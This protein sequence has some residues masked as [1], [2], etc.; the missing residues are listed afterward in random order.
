MV[1]GIKFLLFLQQQT[2]FL[3]QNTKLNRCLWAALMGM[4]MLSCSPKNQEII[5][6][7][8]GTTDVVTYQ[9]EGDSIKI[10]KFSSGSVYFKS[11]KKSGLKGFTE[12]ETFTYHQNGQLRKYAFLVNDSLRY[13][14][15]YTRDGKLES[16]GGCALVYLDNEALY[17]DTVQVNE[18]YF[19][20]LRFALPPNCQFRLLYGDEVEDENTRDLAKYPLQL[21]PLKETMTGFLVKEMQPSVLNKVLYWSLEDTVCHNIEKGVV[22]RKFV[23]TE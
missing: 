19:H 11:Q 23:V 15:F 6:L 2:Y 20:Q 5:Q 1:E 9:T 8:D 3:M 7:P 16:T 17:V 4:T 12:T 22:W 13:F 10:G 14:R 21:L 18:P